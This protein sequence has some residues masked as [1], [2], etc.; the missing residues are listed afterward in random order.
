MFSFSTILLLVT[1]ASSVFAA[2]IAAPDVAVRSEENHVDAV[3][4]WKVWIKREPEPEVQFLRSF[5]VASN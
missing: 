4:H 2:P 1:Y 3:D 5:S